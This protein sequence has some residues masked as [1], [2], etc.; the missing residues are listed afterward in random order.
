MVSRLVLP[1]F[2]CIAAAQALRFNTPAAKHPSLAVAALKPAITTPRSD[3]AKVKLTGAQVPPD[4]AL[5]KL[6][7]RMPFAANFIRLGGGLNILV[8]QALMAVSQGTLRVLPT[9]ADVTAR[10]V[11]ALTTFVCLPIWLVAT[12]GASLGR[13]HAIATCCGHMP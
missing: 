4:A 8:G 6:A 5:A 9:V 10:A 1:F 13:V 12:A 3:I 2:C 11:H 7:I